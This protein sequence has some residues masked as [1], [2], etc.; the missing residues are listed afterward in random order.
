MRLS[1][2]AVLASAVLAVIVVVAATV[3]IALAFID[4]DDEAAAGGDTTAVTGEP[5]E[6]LPA[7]DPTVVALVPYVDAVVTAT[8][9]GIAGLG[10]A[11]GLDDAPF[12]C[13]VQKMLEQVRLDRL[14][15]AGATP[16]TFADKP[17]LVTAGF[18]LEQ[19]E[20]NQ[21]VVDAQA[22]GVGGYVAQVLISGLTA[23]VTGD[24]TPL[25]SAEGTG[26]FVNTIAADGTFT[27]AIVDQLVGQGDPALAI[28]SATVGAFAACPT[29]L[30]DLL[31]NVYEGT[32]LTVS[33]SARACL[34]TEVT[35]RAF[36]V[37]EAV[38]HQDG[39]A[40]DALGREIATACESELVG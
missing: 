7:D 15:A 6:T 40:T 2:P 14:Q 24:G 29:L 26:C 38:V 9:P 21:L 33:D 35:D 30:V 13:T 37:A 12:R 10:Q 32:G 22:C 36:A 4:D 27:P 16:E 11:A 20:V 8:S 31:V 25:A 34:E 28:D 18:I 19:S 39:D 3:V 23:D 17:N 1:T 5:T